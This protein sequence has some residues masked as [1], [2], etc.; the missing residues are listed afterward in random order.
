[1]EELR[2]NRLT[3]FKYRE[4]VVELTLESIDV[5]SSDVSVYLYEKDIIELIKYLNDQLDVK[6]F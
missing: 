5:P 1:M 4:G 3:A 6:F 2:I